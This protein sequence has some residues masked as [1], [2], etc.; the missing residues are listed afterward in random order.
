M[1]VSIEPW[2]GV[3]VQPDELVFILVNV[4]CRIKVNLLYNYILLKG[5]NIN[6]IIQRIQTFISVPWI[7]KK[8]ITVYVSELHICIYSICTNVIIMK[9]E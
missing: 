1:V 7:T 8:G 9:K 6:Q 5:V 4:M 2:T 3:I